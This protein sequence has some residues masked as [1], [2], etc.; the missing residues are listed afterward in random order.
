[1][2]APDFWRFVRQ[3]ALDSRGDAAQVAG[4]LGPLVRAVRRVAKHDELR[5][6]QQV[7]IRPLAVGIT[8]AIGIVGVNQRGQIHQDLGHLGGFPGVELDGQHRP[9]AVVHHGREA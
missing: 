6:G 7:L 1:M 9:V 2:A 8:E 3:L 5:I 4:Y